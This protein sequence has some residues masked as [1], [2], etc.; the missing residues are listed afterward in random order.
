MNHGTAVQDVERPPLKLRDCYWFFGPLV[1]MV[2]LNMMSKSVI[3]AFLARTD[4]PSAALAAFNAAFTFYFAITAASEVT[5]VLCLSFLKSRAD[6][7]RLSTFAAI[8]LSLPITIALAVAFTP[9]GNMAFGSWFGLGSQAQLEARGAVGLLIVSAPFLIVRA[10]A[11]ALLMLARRTFIIT[12][13]TL[14]RLLSLTVSLA[15]LPMWL[16]GA[17]IGAAALVICM[18]TEAIFAWAFAWRHL[19]ELPVARQ[20]KETIARYWSFAWPLIINASAELGSIF[21]INL[22]LGRLR[23]AELAIAAFGVVHGL[24]SL[25]MAPVRNLA[26]SAQALVGRREDVSVLL[27]FSAQLVT[28]FSSAGADVVPHAVARHHPE[29]PD[30]P[31]ARAGVLCRAG[32]GDLVRDGRILGLHRTLQRPTRQG[33]NNGIT[34][35]QRGIAHRDRRRHQL[36][37]PCQSGHQRRHARYSRMDPV[38]CSRVGRKHMASAEAGVVR[39]EVNAN[40]LLGVWQLGTG[41]R[42]AVQLCT[43]RDRRETGEP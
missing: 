5:T 36:D 9:V 33:A 11:F 15:L 24:V 34:R 7:L 8:V 10:N 21:V 37:R 22:F 17:A 1:L 23:T 31:D 30:R 14:V 20:S 3:H 16:N 6:S 38:L 18:A 12:L 28:L 2:E 29:R 27:V 43:F 39:G 35:G 41:R 40:L 19:M 13:S 4:N 26:Q 42:N 25:L 32:P